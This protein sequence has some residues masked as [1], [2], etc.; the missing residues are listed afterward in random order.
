VVAW[1]EL[2][3]KQA[4]FKV[5]RVERSGQRSAA[6]TVTDLGAQRNSGYPRLARSG[7]E[8]IFAWTGTG[9]RLRVETAVARLPSLP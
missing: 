8:L 5:R 4:A 1:V 6:F 9:D 2:A 3:G 7:Q